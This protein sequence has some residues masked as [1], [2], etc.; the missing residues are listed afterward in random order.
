MFNKRFNPSF[1][2]PLGVNM[3]AERS[4]LIHFIF[5]GKKEISNSDVQRI[6]KIGNRSG[7]DVLEIHRRGVPHEY[8]EKGKIKAQLQVGHTS[9]FIM[10]NWEACAVSRNAQIA[11]TDIETL[12]RK[13]RKEGLLK[14]VKPEITQINYSG[15]SG[16]T[17]ILLLSPW[18]A[19]LTAVICNIFSSD[20]EI[21]SI[22]LVLALAL[23]AVLTLI[24]QREKIITRWK[25]RKYRYKEL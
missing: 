11:L 16:Q 22:V 25:I 14:K 8:F 1:E 23:A 17:V 18:L 6:N 3:V 2:P 24:N 15:Y 13:L 5:V 12:E 19:A 7:E 4:A 21:L 20:L 10:K 9:V